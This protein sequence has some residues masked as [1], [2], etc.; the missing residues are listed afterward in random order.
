[1]S[2]DR[3][4]PTTLSLLVLSKV[5]MATHGEIKTGQIFDNNNLFH[6]E[7]LFSVEY[8]GKVGSADRT[9]RYGW[10]STNIPILNPKIYK[11]IV[12][13]GSI[14][15]RVMRGEVTVVF[16]EDTLD[17]ELGGG[18]KAGTGYHFFMKHLKKIK[19]KNAS[20]SDTR[21]GTIKSVYKALE[22]RRAV[23]NSYY[24]LPA[25]YRDYI[26]G[27][28]GRPEEDEVNTLYRRMLSRTSLIDPKRA[29][30]SP[31]LYDNNAYA[32]QIAA[33]A[34]YDHFFDLINGKKK[35][36]QSKW[37]SRKTFNSTANVISPFVDN[38]TGANDPRRLLYTE[39]YVG[40]Y[41][42]LRSAAPVT[43]FQVQN[44]YIPEVF[45]PQMN[46]ARLTNMKTLKMEEFSATAVQKFA[47]LWTTNDGLDK[48]FASLENK[49]ARNVPAMV[50]VE[51]NKYCLG[52]I[53]RDDKTFMFLQDIDDLPEHLDRKKVKPVTI[54]DFIYMSVYGMSSKYYGFITRY[55]VTGY[56]SIYPSLIKLGTTV[57]TNI[58]TEIGPMVEG[59]SGDEVVAINFP[60]HESDY[61]DTMLVASSN[62][63][64]LGGDYDGDTAHLK[65]VMS[66][67]ATSEIRD[68]LN[69]RE[70]Y[71]SDEGDFYFSPER[72]TINA[73]LRF[74]SE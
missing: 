65:M 57:K 38:T 51:G 24:V 22:E 54:Y 25:G 43:H 61:V 37:L 33:V 27:K 72:D 73:T 1:M 55:P 4:N 63:S 46:I 12:S 44:K 21:E 23:V 17:F 42:F 30:I 28:D 60:I 11:N 35:H 10:M 19:F 48:V 40:L 53:Y 26:V 62:L 70:Y 31:E 69:S 29:E 32:T 15:D 68:L 39:T 67:E 52:L 41:Q 59:L 71:I 13:L 47:D 6:P 18:P 74:M 58:L 14:Y 20:G 50:E 56:G 66:E 45:P 2:K 3:Y 9:K 34:L 7:G 49:Q 36:I 64:A 8:F 5:D 16:N